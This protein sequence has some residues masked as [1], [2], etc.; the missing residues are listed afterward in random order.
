[1]K[2]TFSVTLN[3]DKSRALFDYNYKEMIEIWLR[4]SY[5]GKEQDR[6]Y[7]PQLAAVLFKS[8]YQLGLIGVTYDESL[9]G[10]TITVDPRVNMSEAP[11]I[12]ER[13]RKFRKSK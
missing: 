13:R 1:M 10:I 2:M 6:Q 7:Y 4:D 11:V 9:A 5:S 3:D 12:L 8:L